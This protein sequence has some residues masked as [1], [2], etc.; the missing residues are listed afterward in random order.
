MSGITIVASGH[1]AKFAEEVR[2]GLLRGKFEVSVSRSLP[3]ITDRYVVLLWGAALEAEH[4]IDAQALIGLWS[5]G[6]LL[7]ARRDAT[8][9]PLG[10][11]DLPS[12]PPAATAAEVCAAVP[13]VKP[14]KPRRFRSLV[15]IALLALILIALLGAGAWY[16]L[17]AGQR[18]KQAELTAHLE[19]AAKASEE[20]NKAK[21]AEVEA[22]KKLAD[23]RAAE[24]EAIKRGDTAKAKELEEARKKAEAEAAKQAE[25]VKLREAAAKKAVDDA[26]AAQER[27]KQSATEKAKE[28]AKP[29]ETAAVQTPGVAPA[30]TAPAAPAATTPTPSPQ[31]NV[32]CEQLPSRS[33]REACLDDR[34]ANKRLAKAGRPAEA[35][36]KEAS[37]GAPAASSAAPQVA[38]AAPTPSAV[39]AAPEKPN[40]AESETL[41]QQ[42]LAMENGGDVKGAIR[43]YRRAARGGSGKAAKRLG[44]IF[45]KGV[46]GVP[47]D[48]AESLQWYETARQLGETVETAGIR[49]VPGVAAKPPEIEAAPSAPATRPAEPESPKSEPA[50][51]S[52]PVVPAPRRSPPKAAVAAPG[53]EVPKAAAAPS[54]VPVEAAP[55]SA[56]TAAPAKAPKPAPTLEPQEGTE[57]SYVW[58]VVIGLLALAVIILWRTLRRRP[59]PAASA[60]QAARPAT[61]ESSPKFS[62]SAPQATAGGAMLFVSY[63]H[64]DRPRVEPIVSVIE[65]LGR[66][67]WMDRTDITGQTGW[68]GQ[69]VRAIRESRAVVLMASPNSYASDQV[70][71]E[72]Y[73]AM[74]HKKT[75][76]PIE[77]EP[78]ELPDELQYILA[79]FQHHR[80]SS[81]DTREV[82]G[83]ALAAV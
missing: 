13:G 25:A 52:A 20:L 29:V 32:S 8:P 43:V 3:N 6:L 23:A 74:N 19:V 12:L 76:V 4:A 21:Q 66:R 55:A 62:R 1:D 64:K 40:V 61:S 41:Y 60:P 53:P 28:P 78:A 70:V 75:I 24:L 65:E 59:M 15:G 42:A 83:R 37:S 63:S 80:L 82:I 72:L 7:I 73:L 81:G 57:P 17:A 18:A 30:A 14:S 79:P 77:I 48:Y 9:L 34:A 50:P 46:P 16:F 31:A 39:P 51:A 68:A 2:A 47:R 11:R 35:H 26:K 10:L 67:V 33:A 22:Q 58:I 38:A 5:D 71:R 36:K 27:A 44:E 54:P 45:D 69:I 49:G 56:K